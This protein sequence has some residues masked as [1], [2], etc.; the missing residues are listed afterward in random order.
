[1]AGHSKWAGIKHK[2]AAV[3][4]K[5]GKVFTKLI[6][7]ITVAARMGGG[8]PEANPRLRTAVANAKA[9]NMPNEN[10]DRAIKKGTGDLPGESYEAVVYE[11]YGPGGVAV[12]MEVLTD[13]KNRTVAEIRSVFTKAGGQLGENGC[14]AWMFQKKGFIVVAPK[15]AVVEDELMEAALEAGAE[16]FM[17]SDDSYE[18]ITS[19]EAFEDTRSALEAKGVSLAA[20]EV[21]MIP[22]VT[23]AVSSE[24]EAAKLLKMMNALEDLDDVQK[25]YANFDIPDQVMEKVGG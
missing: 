7:E 13:N 16:D 24:G 19:P 20:A 6:R 11:G 25:V 21:T 10:I 23:V 4:A 12:M 15:S 18:I 5:R 2:K 14:V 8:D 3:D 17:A 22:S 1:M 9:A